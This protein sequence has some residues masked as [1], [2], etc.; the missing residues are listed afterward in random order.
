MVKQG[1]KDFKVS[2]DH[3]WVGLDDEHVFFGLT[4]YAQAELGQILSVELPEVGDGVE[5]GEAFGEVESV[6]TVLELVAPVSGTVLAVN[7]ELEN[8]AGMINEDPY[9]EG[10][11]IELRIKDTTE[12]D[13][14]L[15][16]DEYYHYV[17]KTK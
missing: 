4:N 17:F 15:D 2:R 3:I 16:M 1:E 10:W 12:V 13:S 8:H 11:L 6:S 5:K 7:T 14:L 9:S